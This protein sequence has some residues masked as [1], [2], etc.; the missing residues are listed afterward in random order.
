MMSEKLFRL[1]EALFKLTRDRTERDA[2]LFTRDIMLP[3]PLTLISVKS[4]LTVA[5]MECCL[6]CFFTK[7]TGLDDIILAAAHRWKKRR[8]HFQGGYILFRILVDLQKNENPSN[9]LSHFLTVFHRIGCG[10]LVF[11]S[12]LRNVLERARC[13]TVS[14]YLRSS[15]DAPNDLE[16]YIV[17]YVF[18]ARRVQP[19]FANLECQRCRTEIQDYSDLHNSRLMRDLYQ[20]VRSHAI[21]LFKRSNPCAAKRFY[22]NIEPERRRNFLSLQV[23]WILRAGNMKT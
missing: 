16:S 1:R 20:A 13:V 17:N 18:D 19:A 5:K 8:R 6:Q 3:A 12:L 15:D 14:R 23:I 21:R 11:Y 4:L 10:D 9:G 7:W 2:L 22:K